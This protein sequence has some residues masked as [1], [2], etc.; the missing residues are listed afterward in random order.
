[1]EK[2]KKG[3]FAENALQAIRHF[4]PKNH[5]FLR[6]CSQVTLYKACLSLFF[7]GSANVVWRS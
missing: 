1:M 4:P 2:A 6:L 5:I 7:P 3:A